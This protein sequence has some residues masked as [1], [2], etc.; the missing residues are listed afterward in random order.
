LRALAEALGAEVSWD[1]QGTVAVKKNGVTVKLQINGQ[2]A[3]QN[4]QSISLDVPARLSH[5][6]TLVPVRFLSQAL[7]AKVK[8]D[9]ETGS[10]FSSKFCRIHN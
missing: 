5:G 4:E 1:A 8:W 7:G 2:V 3:Y 6:R 10:I 9:A